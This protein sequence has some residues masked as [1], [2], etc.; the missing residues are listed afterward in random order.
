ME[1]DKIAAIN[2]KRNESAM[3]KFKIKPQKD[4]KDKD[5]A[6]EE[7][8]RLMAIND[9]EEEFKKATVPIKKPDGNEIK[10]IKDFKEAMD[11]H[12]QFDEFRK[13]EGKFDAKTQREILDFSVLQCLSLFHMSQNCAICHKFFFFKNTLFDD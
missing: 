11:F 3:Y 12:N 2:K 10:N 8:N 1:D 7:L 5:D 9:P 4:I 13:N 6:Q